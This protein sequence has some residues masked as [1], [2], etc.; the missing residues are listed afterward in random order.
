MHFQVVNGVEIMPEIGCN[1]M[2]DKFALAGMGSMAQ[3]LMD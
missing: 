2:H 3:I 1:S